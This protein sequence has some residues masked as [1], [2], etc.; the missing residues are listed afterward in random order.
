MSIGLADAQEVCFVPLTGPNL[1]N[2]LLEGQIRVKAEDTEI[3]QDTFAKFKGKV[4]IDSFSAKIKADEA[5]L[6]RQTQTLNASG[7]VSF[8]DNNITVSSQNVQLNR[9]SN[10]LVIEQAL[11]QLNSVQGHGKAERIGLGQQTGINLVES[12]FTTCPV[13]DEVWRIQATNIES[14][15]TN[16]EVW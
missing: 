5:V 7:N 15:Q 3:N 12:S 16:Q 13:E 14:H 8:Q 6:N 1:D 4:E 11:Y 10:E 9:L 2:S